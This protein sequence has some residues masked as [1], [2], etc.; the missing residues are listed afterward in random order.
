MTLPSCRSESHNAPKPAMAVLAMYSA[1]GPAALRYREKK[2]PIK[3]TSPELGHLLLA[4]S[5]IALFFFTY[6]PTDSHDSFHSFHARCP[7]REW[8]R[9]GLATRSPAFAE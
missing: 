5:R 9:T 3:A 6:Q 7:S 1:T 4:S 2:Q 8:A